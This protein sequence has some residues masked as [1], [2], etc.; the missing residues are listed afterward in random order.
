MNSLN[1]DFRGG[2]L[3]ILVVRDGSVRYSKLVK[4]FS[5]ADMKSASEKLLS[6]I[7]EAGG[8]KGRISIILPADIVKFKILQAPAMDI[9]DAK[10]LV[11]REILKEIKG[12]KIV[13]GIKKLDRDK[14]GRQDILAEYALTDDVVRYL[15]LLKAC[16]IR[17][18]IMTTS[19][20]GNFQLFSRLRPAT[21][22]NEAVIEIGLNYI[23][24]IVFNNGKLVDYKKTLMSPI[25]DA[26]FKSKD[27]TLEQI[28]K[29]K[30]YTIVDTLYNF[31]MESEKGSPKEK[32]TKLWIGGLGSLAENITGY[33]S[34]GL[35]ISSDL[36]NPFG[37]AAEGSS[38]FSAIAG[39]SSIS[40][41]GQS[42]NL[43]PEEML[44]ERTRLL[45]RTLL[46]ASLS[47]YVILL[48][49]TYIILN[50]SENE[51]KLTYDKLGSDEV[52][53][54]GRHK[55]E[56]SYSIGQDTY[57]RIISGSTGLYGVFR[58]IA[59][60]TPSGVTLN[61]M[62]VERM[63]DII[64][65]KID[66]TIKYSDENIRNAVLSKYLTSLEG[67]NKIRRVKPPEIAISQ[68]DVKQK[69]ISV[70]TI[71]EVVR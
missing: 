36:I 17:P 44:Y 33:I 29:I 37:T 6:E 68:S 10:K 20:E 11:R 63:Q 8:K 39:V 53:R 1:I 2:F 52:I 54:T 18:D 45:R 66:A 30:I 26:K 35:G 56:D 24:I 9:E 57:A 12:Q 41:T 40:K 15:D 28:Y 47:F 61:S 67:S 42:I 27:M 49:G 5:L 43:F 7:K 22:G 51:L 16:R 19:L 59:N 46:A 14:T 13:F 23:E 48:A 21:D 34:D 70:K 50:R 71:Y 60:L 38:A 4:G 62:Q 64:N 58:D 31:V 55:T 69:E 25:D 3:R 32:L 65:I